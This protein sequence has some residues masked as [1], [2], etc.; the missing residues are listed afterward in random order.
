MYVSMYVCLYSSFKCILI[1]ADN[2]Y[3][4][5]SPMQFEISDQI[6][7]TELLTLCSVLILDMMQFRCHQTF[8]LILK[9]NKQQT[10]CE[11]WMVC[12]KSTIHLR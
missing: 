3:C 8:K 1:L 9:E 4:K 7:K 11:I 6:L 12:H 2:F 5:L 10:G